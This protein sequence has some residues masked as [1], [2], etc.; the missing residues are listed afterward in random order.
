MQAG[1]YQDI[2]ERKLCL[3]L[4]TG[5]ANQDQTGYVEF[6]GEMT[7]GVLRV[8]LTLLVCPKIAA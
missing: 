3:R 6:T 8:A 7:R 2:T 4:C 5:D 1:C